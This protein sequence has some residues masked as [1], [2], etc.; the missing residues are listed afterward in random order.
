M[1]IICII[2]NKYINICNTSLH[3]LKEVHIQAFYSYV[4][5]KVCKL[6]DYI[7]FQLFN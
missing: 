6:A 2:C 4:Y 5:G 3:L 7:C 1:V